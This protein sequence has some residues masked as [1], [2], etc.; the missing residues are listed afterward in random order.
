MAFDG[1]TTS[2]FPLR[3]VNLL[4]YTFYSAE[5]NKIL[6]RSYSIANAPNQNNILEL[7]C[8]YVEGGLASN[9]LFNLKPG[10]SIEA[11]GPF[12][13]FILKQEEKPS[14][15]IL[16]ATGTG[17][18]P[19]RSMISDLKNRLKQNPELN[20]VVM[21]GVRSPKELLFGDDFCALA[22]EHANC[23]FKALYSREGYDGKEMAAHEQMGHVQIFFPI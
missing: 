23:N 16:I 22:S 21:Q 17:I 4:P 19:Y 9:L 13:L 12:G 20:V 11:S 3:Q 14:R 7:A 10:D 5:K 1:K 8:S 18:A 2:P 15:Y 6:H